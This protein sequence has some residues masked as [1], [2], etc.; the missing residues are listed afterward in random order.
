MLQ[1]LQRQPLQ[2][3]QAP[4]FRRHGPSLDCNAPSVGPG[5]V[6]QELIT[7][8]WRTKNIEFDTHYFMRAF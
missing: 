3:L 1:L 5:A 2:R 8:I 6:P 7:F 4:E